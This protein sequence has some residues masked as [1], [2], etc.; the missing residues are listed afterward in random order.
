LEFLV[1]VVEMHDNVAE[2][3]NRDYQVQYIH[4][5]EGQVREIDYLHLAPHTP[6]ILTPN[7]QWCATYPLLLVVITGEK[8]R[9]AVNSKHLIKEALAKG[10]RYA[11]VRTR[12]VVPVILFRGKNICRSSTL[13]HK[14]ET[15]FQ[16][17]AN[18]IKDTIFVEDEEELA[19]QSKTPQPAQPAAPST[20]PIP[21]SHSKSVPLYGPQDVSMSFGLGESGSRRSVSQNAGLFNMVSASSS[22][23][24]GALSPAQGVLAL[25]TSPTD[26]PPQQSTPTTSLVNAGSIIADK[27]PSLMD[28]YRNC[29]IALLAILRITH[30]RC[31][32][33]APFLS[34]EPT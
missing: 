16:T 15:V 26:S 21:L 33:S 20:Q 8:D 5:E 12:F 22:F 32:A 29:D 27:E 19:A 14:L 9:D 13:S 11:R 30:V 3:F 7:V 17:T 34:A 31:F 4:N 28:K 24:S 18:S 1:Q 23:I 25:S 2:L 6:R 10:A